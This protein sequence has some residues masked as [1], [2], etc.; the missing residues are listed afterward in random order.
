MMNRRTMIGSMGAAT[1]M[2]S[3]TI[4]VGQTQHYIPLISKGFSHQFW[5]AVKLG[6]EMA[7]ES[8]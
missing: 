1:V 5:Q 3:V 8:Q 6:S 2:G 4:A 7:A